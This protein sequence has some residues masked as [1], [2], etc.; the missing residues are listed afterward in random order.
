M[1]SDV[2]ESHAPDLRA[3][4]LN[5]GSL[6]VDRVL[7]VP[8]LVRPGETLG[9]RSLQVFAG[10]KGAN[11]SVALARAGAAVA[12]CGKVGPDGEWLIDRLA[13]E[14]IDTSF[15]TRSDGP[16]GQALIQVADDGQ[17][18]IVLVAG[19]NQEITSQ[20]V[21]SALSAC[22]TGTLVLTQ[23]ETSQVAHVIEQAAARGLSVAF[24]PA[25]FA[26]A[27]EHYPIHK[28][29]LLIVN[30]SE[31]HG[32]TGHSAPDAIVAA[33]RSRWP[34]TDVILTLGAAG[35]LYDGREGRM[36]VSALPV[37]VVDT[38]AAGD[39]FIGFFLAGRLSGAS[40][41]VSLEDACR[42]AAISVGRPGAIDSIPSRIEVRKFR[43]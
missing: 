42:A 26:S 21:D 39:T 10:G 24:N 33:L 36:H 16:T 18:T 38:T 11:Q 31:G 27:V 3:R 5:V 2:N 20:D 22:S 15:V 6:N 1:S 41:R 32:L 14:G 13:A 40:V 7:R 4:V 9:S 12:H 28:V 30:E 25:P 37:E 34:N 29:A 43:P 35:V 8:H 23:N 19:A 17:N